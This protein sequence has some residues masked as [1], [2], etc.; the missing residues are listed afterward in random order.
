[1]GDRFFQRN[2][3]F[4]GQQYTRIRPF[5]DFNWHGFLLFGLVLRPGDRAIGAL[6]IG[7][8]KIGALKIGAPKIGALKIGALK[9]GAPTRHGSRCRRPLSHNRGDYGFATTERRND[10]IRVDITAE[11]MGNGFHAINGQVRQDL[12][13]L[14]DL[15]CTPAKEHKAIPIS[16]LPAWA[17]IAWIGPHCPIEHVVNYLVRNRHGPDEAVVAIVRGQRGQTIHLREDLA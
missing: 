12:D 9:I 15:S 5:F 16:R 13:E 3:R 2:C 8:P 6:K 11:R 4:H 1:M 17:W 14:P 10:T 7:A